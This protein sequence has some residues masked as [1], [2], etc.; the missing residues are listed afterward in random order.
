MDCTPRYFCD[1]GNAPN[2]THGADTDGIIL[3]PK[4]ATILMEQT[5]Q[6]S[7]DSNPITLLTA[8]QARVLG[9]LMEKQ[10]ATPKYYPL[11]PN[12]LTAACNQKSSR[13]PV[14]ILSEGEVRHEA[15]VLAQKGIVRVESG[16]RTYKVFHL[17]KRYFDLDDAELSVLTVLLLRKPQTVNDIFRRTSR[18]YAF[19]Q[20]ADVSCVL[21]RLIERESALAV[22]IP[23]SP[24]QREQRYFHTLFGKLDLESMAKE[25]AT[26]SKTNRIDELEQ[27]VAALEK[28][29]ENL[30]IK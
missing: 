21:E 18:M 10:L 26:Q 2:L 4:N 19:D 30:L 13:E 9:A 23:S 12:A 5:E 20:I 29:I 25:S 7:S 8:E 24:G 27:R 11:T 6:I 16:E 3:H 14:M 22:L 28:Q 1:N 17:A 15:N